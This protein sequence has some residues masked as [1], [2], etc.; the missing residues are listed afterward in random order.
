MHDLHNFML[1]LF[2]KFVTRVFL[3]EEIS[4]RFNIEVIITR[5]P[6]LA[7]THSMVRTH[8][9][10]IEYFARIMNEPFTL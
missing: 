5:F 3:L 8:L 6:K 4:T 10:K 2:R 9:A 1:I 7:G